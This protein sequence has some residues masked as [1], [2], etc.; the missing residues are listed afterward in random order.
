MPNIIGNLT[1]MSK[2]IDAAQKKT[3]RLKEKGSRAAASKVANA[4]AELESATLQ[5]DSQAPFVFEQLQAV[6]EG[7]LNHLR[8]LL[9]QYQ[10]HEVDQ[11]QRSKTAAEDC[12][13]VILNVQTA[14]EI[15]TFAARSITGRPRIERQRSRQALSASTTSA[16]NTVASSM[17][18]PPATPPHH[19]D[20]GSSQKSGS[21]MLAESLLPA[22]TLQPPLPTPNLQTR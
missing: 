5:W 20:D 7:R 1:A 16:S 15:R 4:S 11:V 12:L 3:D 19:G 2:E 9:T 6:D 14:D 17:L 22:F 21:G 13:N 8:D 10:T 18:A